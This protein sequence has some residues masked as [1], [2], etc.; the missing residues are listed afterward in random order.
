MVK[1]MRIMHAELLNQ[2]N[3][4]FLQILQLMSKRPDVW[5]SGRLDIVINCKLH[6]FHTS[7]RGEWTGGHRCDLNFLAAAVKLV[8]NCSQKCCLNGLTD[9]PNCY[10]SLK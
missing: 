9:F 5:M 2:I 6:A 4:M 3:Q 1:V 10:V 7:L 8:I